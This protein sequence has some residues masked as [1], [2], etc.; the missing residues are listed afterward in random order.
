MTRTADDPLVRTGEA[1]VLLALTHGVPSVANRAGIMQLVDAVAGALPGHRVSI[2]FLD[3]QHTDIADA[4][5]AFVTQANTVILPLVLSA[6]FH[7]RTGIAKGIER[8]EGVGAELADELGPDDRLV[9]V[10]AERIEETGLT[11]ADSVVLAAAGSSDARAVREC[12]ETGR[13][14]AVRLGRPVTVGFIAAAMPRLHDAIDMVRDVHPG[15]RVVVG[16]YLLAPGNFYDAVLGAGGD[17][18]ATPLLLP[19][20]AAPSELVALVLDRYETAV[21]ERSDG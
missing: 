8:L 4:L 19:E 2:A 14:L 7:M 9:R 16:T 3:V 5:T 18:V 21:R 15:T 13:R 6:G 20:L 10:L 17:V 1:L 11:P 12:F